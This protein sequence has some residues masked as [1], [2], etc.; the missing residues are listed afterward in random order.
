MVIKWATKNGP[1]KRAG[2][3]SRKVVKGHRNG[4]KRPKKD[5]RGP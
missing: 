5:H 1:E 3:D 4:I 2:R